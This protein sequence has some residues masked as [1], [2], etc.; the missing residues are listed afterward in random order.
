[1]RRRGCIKVADEELGTLP[2]TG[3]EATAAVRAIFPPFFD[4]RLSA[5]PASPGLHLSTKD[6]E[7]LVDKLTHI[8]AGGTD[9][10]AVFPRK[11][12]AIPSIAAT[13]YMEIFN[14]ALERKMES[15]C[16]ELAILACS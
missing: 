11:T 5:C 15:R 6:L 7:V 10:G 14:Q 13:A 8:G 4:S 3:S 12:D 9:L 2:A 16:V 1:M